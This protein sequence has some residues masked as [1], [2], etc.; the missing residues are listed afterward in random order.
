MKKPLTLAFVVLSA[1]LLITGCMGPFES[2]EDDTAP[3]G[4]AVTVPE[5][6][7]TS[8]PKSYTAE[9]FEFQTVVE[10][11][12]RVDVKLYP[13]FSTTGEPVPLTAEEVAAEARNTLAT[14][15]DDKG[16]VAFQAAFAGG[17]TLE[18]SLVL[19]TGKEAYRLELSRPGYEPAF[20]PLEKAPQQKS[21]S[22]TAHLKQSRSGSVGASVATEVNP[23]YRV[24]AGDFFTVAYEDYFPN[25][26]DA[27][28]ND[29]VVQYNIEVTEQFID[30][31][32]ATFVTQYVVEATARA[33]AAG[34]DHEFGFALDFPNFAS[35]Y[36]YWYEE[37]ASDGT[38]V[39]REF[40]DSSIGSARI[41]LF[42]KTKQAFDRGGAPVSNDNGSNGE[43]LS[44]GLKAGFTIEFS[45]RTLQVSPDD[46]EAP[47]LDPYLF[48]HNTGYDVHLIGKPPF[49]GGKSDTPEEDFLDQAGY[50]RALLV[51]TAWPHPLEITQIDD[52][53]T[54]FTAWRTSNGAEKQDWY[55]RPN[56]GFVFEWPANN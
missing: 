31:I 32:G 40:S 12:L 6:S 50:P 52:A 44:K 16:E 1:L 39:R 7:V 34:F 11:P 25:V 42:P 14:L 55:E 17:T 45:P 41:P 8:V 51:P 24:P 28:F 3:Q 49:E 47:P 30:V 38:V 36:T 29:F 48:V 37:V 19:P 20:V 9:E 56:P 54:D 33:R 22:V 2:D 43:P 4:V 26:G 5:A 23:R 13:A 27:D 10:V 53:Y 46:I 15:Y 18:R 21:I 35:D